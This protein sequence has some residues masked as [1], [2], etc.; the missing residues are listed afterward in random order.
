MKIVI[1][2]PDDVLADLVYIKMSYKKS[3][4]E[5]I[6]LRIL[7]EKFSSEQKIYFDEIDH[8]LFPD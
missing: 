1:D 7:R 3:T 8:I 4:L 5:E 2:I 6:I